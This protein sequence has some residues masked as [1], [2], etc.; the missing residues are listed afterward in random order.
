MTESFNLAFQQNAGRRKT[1]STGRASLQPQRIFEAC[2]RAVGKGHVVRWTPPPASADGG[3]PGTCSSMPRGVRDPRRR[4]AFEFHEWQCGR[5]GVRSSCTEHKHCKKC[6]AKLHKL[7]T[8][9]VEGGAEV[10]AR[11]GSAMQANAAQK[12]SGRSSLGPLQ[13]GTGNTAAALA[14]ELAELK[15]VWAN[16]GP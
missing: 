9:T 10:L 14:K 13:A 1:T 5:D 7:W 2:G 16:P 8:A 4:A 6:T 3:P 12:S 15:L 11:Q